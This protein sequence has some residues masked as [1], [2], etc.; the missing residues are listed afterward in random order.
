MRKAAARITNKDMGKIHPATKHGSIRAGN[1]K[2]QSTTEH[3]LLTPPALYIDKNI[4]GIHAP[5]R[6]QGSHISLSA[7]RVRDPSARKTLPTDWF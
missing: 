5:G 6:V 3:D 7:N 4:G 1:H 2:H